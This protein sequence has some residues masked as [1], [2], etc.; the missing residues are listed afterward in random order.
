MSH[1]VVLHV[2]LHYVQTWR[3]V[4]EVDQHSFKS[5]DFCMIYHNF[6]DSDICELMKLAK[7]TECKVFVCV[8]GFVY[9]QGD[10]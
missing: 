1:K 5:D 10:L 7:W 2:E 3:D 8:E 9:N 6:I 4:A